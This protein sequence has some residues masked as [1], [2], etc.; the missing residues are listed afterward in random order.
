MYRKMMTLAFLS[1][2]VSAAL[3]APTEEQVRVDNLFQQNCA[4]CHAADRGGYI[5]PGLHS[6]RLVQSEIA[7]RGT[8]MTG[9]PDTLMP[10]FV[11]RLPDEDIRSEEH[12]S[13]LQSRE[14][15][16]CR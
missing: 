7:L 1:T 4:V 16:V 2:T 14:K 10:P 11:G 8:I 6:D 12:T 15:L 3:A 5:A 9:I 13:E